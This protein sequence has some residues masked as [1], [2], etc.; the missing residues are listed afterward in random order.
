MRDYDLDDRRDR[1]RVYELVL[2]EGR[3]DDV[4]RYVKVDELVALWDDLVLP[5]RVAQAWQAWF[6]E[7]RGLDLAC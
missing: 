5:P 4:Q 2:T 3:D 6:K 1:A 7:H